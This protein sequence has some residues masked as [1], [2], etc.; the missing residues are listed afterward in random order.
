[1][2]R[3]KALLSWGEST[4]IEWQVRQLADAGID[5]IVIVL[6]H[7]APRL[8]KVVWEQIRPRVTAEIRAVVNEEYRDGRASSLRAG[9]AGIGD[10]ADAV[11]VLS[12]DQPRPREVHRRLLASHLGSEALITVPVSE[13]KRGHPVV[14]SGALLPGLRSASEERRG[15]HGILEEHSADVREHAFVLLQHESMAGEPDMAALYIHID[16]NTPEDYEE[17]KA[18]FGVAQ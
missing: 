10:H 4:L 17:A 1:M 11:V 3:P 9:A 16:I 2:G 13:G 6:G 5:D 8:M 18:L 15:L 7:D 14:L 12:V